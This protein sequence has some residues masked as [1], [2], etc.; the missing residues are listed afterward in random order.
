MASQT[1]NGGPPGPPGPVFVSHAGILPS[2]FMANPPA[3]SFQNDDDDDDDDEENDSGG[4]S[5]IKILIETPIRISGDNNL[6]SI[7]PSTTSSKVAHAVMTSLRQMS[8]TAGGIPMIDEDGRPR[9]LR[10]RVKAETIIEGARNVVG[11]RA[12]FSTMM[13]N[14]P[15]KRSHEARDPMRKRERAGSEPVEMDRKRLRMD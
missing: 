15:K 2:Q 8:S 7:E 14:G 10:V 12:V 5:T 11:E 4:Q 1:S 9:P 13:A 3:H 6:V